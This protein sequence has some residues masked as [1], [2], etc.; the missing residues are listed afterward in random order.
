MKQIQDLGLDIMVTE[1]DVDDVDVPGPKVAQTVSDKY[2]QFL[3]IVNPYVRVITFEALQDDPAA[4]HTHNLFLR[5][6]DASGAAYMTAHAFGP[7]LTALQRPGGSQ[8]RSPTGPSTPSPAAP[9][10]AH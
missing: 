3:D 8:R 7:A 9:S 10:A 2:S 4:P 1:L 5:N 6:K